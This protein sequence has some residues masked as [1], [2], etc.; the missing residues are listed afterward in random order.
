MQIQLGEFGRMNHDPVF[1]V[2]PPARSHRYATGQQSVAHR[3]S[4]N[5]D[6][7]GDLRGGQ[8]QPQVQ[9]SHQLIHA[10][11]L[12]VPATSATAGAAWVD[13]YPGL[14][15]H[16]VDPLPVIARDPPDLIGGQQ[17]AGV[18]VS[19]PLRFRCIW[20][21]RRAALGRAVRAAARRTRLADARQA[22]LST[23]ILHDDAPGDRGL[24]TTPVI[25]ALSVW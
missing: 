19:H 12:V 10:P 24:W 3:V 6:E 13:R 11:G 22:G 15:Q 16:P 2:I 23:A 5:P 7:S 21:V 14:P 18:Q 8:P 1:P 25:E 17:L 4:G 9:V 20:Q